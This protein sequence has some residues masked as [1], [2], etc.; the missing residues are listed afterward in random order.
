M[1]RLITQ[2]LAAFALGAASL[3][4]GV[5]HAYPDG[6]ITIVV[7]YP[8]GGPVDTMGRLLSERM[9]N[10][11]GV[12]VVVENRPGAGGNIGSNHVARSKPDGHTV[13]MASGS[14]ITMNEFIYSDL[15]FSPADDFTTISVVGDMPLI[16]SVNPEVPVSSFTELV[17][18]ARKSP[19]EVFFSSPGNGTT[20]HAGQALFNSETGT[21]TTHVPYKG[22]AASAT[23]VMAGEVT[24]AID[25]PPSLLP[26]I[27]SGRIKALAIA[28]PERIPQLPDVPTTAELGMPGL[29]VVAWFPLVAPKDTPPEIVEILNSEVV[30]ALQDPNVLERFEALAITPVGN[31][32]EEANRFTD[33]ERARWGDVIKAANIRIE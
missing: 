23:A 13:L 33:E 30:K 15:P 24:G 21:N 28:G 27:Q 12:P 14:I 1:R 25:S 11:L 10:S 31:S 4:A 2:P 17:E 18:L 7:P 32:V 8:P 20:P 16:V 9:S 6:S 22:G 19:D 3:M 29:N 26:H 5:A